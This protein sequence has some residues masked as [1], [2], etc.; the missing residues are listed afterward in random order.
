MW[1]R[2]IKLPKINYGSSLRPIRYNTYE[3]YYDG[4]PSPYIQHIN[5]HKLKN[6]KKF[7]K[8]KLEK[9]RPFRFRFEVNQRVYVLYII[10]KEVLSI[11]TDYIICCEYIYIYIVDKSLISFDIIF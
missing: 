8:I 2:K 5:L 10:C 9:T 3:H 1:R 7:K 6:L 11:R 4:T